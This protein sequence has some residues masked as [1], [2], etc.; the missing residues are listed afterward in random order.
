MYD[1]LWR[2]SDNCDVPESRILAGH[3]VVFL[4]ETF[5]SNSVFLLIKMNQHPYWRIKHLNKPL[6]KLKKGKS[7]FMLI[8]DQLDLAL[9]NLVQEN[10]SIDTGK[11]LDRESRTTCWGVTSNG[12]TSLQ[13]E[14]HVQSS[15]WYRN[16]SY[17][18]WLTLDNYFTKIISSITDSN[19]HFL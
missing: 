1:R 13:G 19:M 3:C 17:T 10:W 16:W 15:S 14:V 6:E 12:P 5:H 8:L 7:K 18:L 4:G 2:L 11:I 9:D